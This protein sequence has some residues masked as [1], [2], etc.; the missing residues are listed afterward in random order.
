MKCP[1][2]EREMKQ[3][4]ASFMSMQGLEQIS[5]SFTADS[6]KGKGFFR[7]R[8]ENKIVCSGDKTK[9]YYCSYCNKIVPFI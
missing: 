7:R 6:E 5:V 1:K 2:C 4:E 9:S 3:G 8:T